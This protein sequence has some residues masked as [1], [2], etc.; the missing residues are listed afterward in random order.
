MNILCELVNKECLPCND[1]PI[2][3]ISAE[4]PDVD[5]FIGFRDFRGNP[6]L[7]VI[8]AQL[9][10]KSI[11]FSKVS[12]QEADDCARRQAQSCVWKTWKDPIKPPVPPG[13][14]SPGGRGKSPNTPGGI[15]PSN[16]NPPVKTFTNKLQ[17]CE[18]D[19]PDGSPFSESVAA[20]TINALSQVFADEQAQSLACQRA[21]TERICFS[22]GALPSKCV[23][24]IY[25]FQLSAS[26]GTPFTTHDYDWSVA[27]GSLPPGLELDPEIGLISGL[28]FSSGNFDFTVQVTDA[29]GKTQ[30]KGFSICIMEIVTEATLPQATQNQPYAQPLIE[31]PA[32]VSSEVWTLVSGDLPP[33]ITLAANGAL[34]GTPTDL[35]SSEFTVQVA[36]TCGGSQV[37][38]QKTFT[39]EVISGVDCMGEA[40]SIEDTIWTQISPPAAGTI[41]IALGDGT[42]TGVDPANSFVESEGIICN[43]KLDPYNFTVD[44]QWAVAGFILVNTQVIVRLNGVDNPSPVFAANGAYVFNFAGQLQSG[45]NTVRIYCTAV[46][47]FAG[48]LNG[49]CQIRPLVPPP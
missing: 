48:T 32:S 40:Q 47:V 31:E 2:A 24:D 37:T 5:V 4:A 36:A 35:G 1:D 39:L 30:S 22:S 25:S 33:G 44:V 41:T 38:C 12:Q 34:N 23:D 6:P 3:N 14:N 21:L 8:F 11:C 15:P 7:G 16:P 19:C 27:S 9:G 18:Q 45:I 46:G 13:P 42:F 10:C 28:P 49:T 29:N 17:T 26:G 43:P 20:G